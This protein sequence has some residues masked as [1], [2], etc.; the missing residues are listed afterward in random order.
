MTSRT[1]ALVAASASALTRPSSCAVASSWSRGGTVTESGSALYSAMEA[2]DRTADSTTA[3]D[4]S[5]VASVGACAQ[6]E[7]HVQGDQQGQR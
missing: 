1:T 6:I 2:E 3:V 7:G 5:T 4:K